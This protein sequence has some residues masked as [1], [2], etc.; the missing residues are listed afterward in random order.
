MRIKLEQVEMNRCNE[1]KICGSLINKELS[2]V[3]MNVIQQQ[4]EMDNGKDKMKMVP[5]HKDK[6]VFPS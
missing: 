4:V 1:K 3:E 5:T 6:L 2:K